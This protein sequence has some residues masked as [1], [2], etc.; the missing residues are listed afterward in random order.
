M[1]KWGC[2]IR[3][4]VRLCLC[5]T[6]KMLRTFFTRL[7]LICIGWGYLFYMILY[8]IFWPSFESVVGTFFVN[9]IFNEVSKFRSK[10][11]KVFEVNLAAL[12]AG[13]NRHLSWISTFALVLFQIAGTHL[14]RK[15]VSG[16]TT[17]LVFFDSKTM[18]C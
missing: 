4:Q 6:V 18:F 5:K 7:K 16:W 8:R 3:V 14:I 17:L 2:K 9:K 11:S 10:M 12:K 13:N 1:V 15:V